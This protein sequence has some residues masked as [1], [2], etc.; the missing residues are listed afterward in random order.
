MHT[1]YHN[2]L[3]CTVFQHDLMGTGFEVSAPAIRILIDR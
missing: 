1:L 3:Q 2:F